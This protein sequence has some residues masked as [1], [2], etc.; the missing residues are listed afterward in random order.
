M[1]QTDPN[2]G[3][4]APC[5]RC[6]AHDCRELFHAVLA[7]EYSDPAYGA[8]NLLTVDAH[9]L[10][11]L[12]D[13]GVKNNAFQLVRLCW[14]LER[15]G[16]PKIGQGPRWLQA[17]FDDHPELPVLTPPARRGALTSTDVYGA[18]NPEEHTRRAYRWARSLWEAWRVHHHWARGWLRGRSSG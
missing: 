16:D 5:K 2:A 6:G 8:V 3:R 18:P 17:A 11:H 9:A 7:L 10:Q 13:H 1:I 14:L 4:P 15:R 12:E